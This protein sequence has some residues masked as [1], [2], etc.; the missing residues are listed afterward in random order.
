MSDIQ[1]L[2]V[3]HCPLKG[4]NLVEASAGTGKTWNLCGLYLRLILEAGLTVQQILVVTFT[5]AATAEL[6][7][8]IRQR[9]L[10]TLAYLACRT[11]GEDP[12]SEPTPSAPSDPSDHADPFVRGLLDALLQGAGAGTADGAT[13]P[14]LPDYLHRLQQRL[15]LALASFDEAAI[16]TIHGFC[17]RALTDT[18][19]STGMPFTL[20]LCPD[21]R[22]L[23]R[24][25]V[26]AAWRK[27]LIQGTISPLLA[28]HLI[29]EKES[30]ETWETLLAQYQEKPLAR[31]RWP[32]ALATGDPLALPGK[33]PDTLPPGLSAS[34]AA[35]RAL[36]RAEREDI[37]GSLSSA[38]PGQLNANSY[39]LESV[40]AG[41]EWWDHYFAQ[42]LPLDFPGRE[43]DRHPGAK[44]LLFSQARIALRTKKGKESPRHPFFDLVQTLLEE[45]YGFTDQLQDAHLGLRKAMLEESSAGLRQLKQEQRQVAFDDLLYQVYRALA[46]ANDGT[47]PDLASALRSRYPAA[48]IDEFQDTDPLQYAIFS[49]IYPPQAS[50][51]GG[52]TGD[53]SLFLI[54]DPK[55]A[56]Y[57]FRNADLHTYLAARHATPRHYTLRHNQRSL[58]PLIQGCNALF[59]HNPRAFLLPGL[60]FTPA[61]A[62]EK[63]RP[64][65]E[66]LSRTPAADPGGGFVLWTLPRADADGGNGAGPDAATTEPR[67]LSREA[68][69]NRV[70]EA[71]AGEIARLLGAARAGRLRCDGQAVS[72][73]QIAVLVR[74]HA[75]GSLIKAALARRGIGSVELA[76]ASVFA[77][78][79]AQEL[80]W[81]LAAIHEPSRVARVRGALATGLMGW[82]A[83][84]I[85]ALEADERALQGVLDRFLS[86]REQWLRRGFVR[87]FRA[88]LEQAGIPGRLLAQAD[89]ERRLTNLLHLGELI[90]AAH[91]DPGTPPETL[92]NWL[93]E[94]RER[95]LAGR[96]GSTDTTQLRLESDRNLVQIV[97]IHKS[98]GLEYEFVFCPFLWD[99]QPPQ[100]SEAGALAYHDAD[101]T[102]VLD[103]RILGDAER[104]AI[105]ERQKED[106]DAEFL[107]LVYVALTRAVLR[108]YLVVGIYEGG[109]TRTSTGQSGRGLLNW[110]AAGAGLDPS[111]WASHK[112]PA[113]TVEAAWSA[114]AAAHP[115][116]FS[117][118][119]L[120]RLPGGSGEAA[121]QQDF[122]DLPPGD[123]DGAPLTLAALTPPRLS[124]GFRTGSF[125]H[126]VAGLHH[127]PP[128]PLDTREEQARDHDA[129]AV[130]PEEER[131]PVNEPPAPAPSPQ[132]PARSG[133]PRPVD[134]RQGTLDLGADPSPAAEPGLPLADD[135]LLFPR[136][137][138]AG[139]CLHAMLE[140]GEFTDPGTWDAAIAR[141]LTEFPQPLPAG[142][143]REAQTTQWQAMA[144]RL[145]TSV[146][147]TPLPALGP[148]GE[149][150]SFQLGHLEPA[151]RRA[152]MEFHLA[153]PGLSQA[154]LQT[155]LR[156]AGYPL[157]DL[158]PDGVPMRYLKGFMD[159]V[160]C[161]DGRYYVLDWKSNHLGDREG[162]YQAA[163]M[164]RAMVEHAYSLQALLYLVA[165]HRLLRFRLPDYDYDRH[166][167]GALYL[168]LRGV[169]PE[170][171]GAGIHAHR[172]SHATVAALDALLRGA[173]N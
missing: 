129:Q 164:Q 57:S 30:P 145:L 18:P 37:V 69:R 154:R 107:R 146:M 93:A 83:P 172:P 20:E 66:D 22:E 155:W 12:G 72:P 117:L 133:R 77:T 27:H 106:E 50:A 6:R 26:L 47:A 68:A 46:E 139:D 5:N 56:I 114:L 149:I 7:E 74:S 2:D 112:L 48:L 34:F 157:P 28:A 138:A 58:E 91:P 63:P 162:D 115:E 124:P 99:A 36:W 64:V 87:M 33:L 31:L 90:Q 168:F 44:A 161:H 85:L 89:G 3:F 148:Q 82:S 141:A 103:F 147:T 59:S 96:E 97:T 79:D 142:V 23:R 32:D 73:G 40:T 84:E 166:V 153:S 165:L 173:E 140:Y 170:W 118:E 53:Y 122:L 163:G 51:D 65:L 78:T 150:G 126:L 134:P 61:L 128:P 135:I 60:T 111:E 29:R 125:S 104:K 144:K 75:Q 131:P 35:A 94:R 92:L 38:I 102:P 62:G 1:D 11:E 159:L 110:L 136:G 14:S 123:G 10:D 116:A 158:G 43:D 41:A 167:G 113:E 169:R 13:R 108:C 19:F 171:P 76:Q 160:F 71:T 120:P 86:A 4:A 130:P 49:H 137:P 101:G 54:G 80:E 8:R 81:L 95:A 9:L 39:R 42:G 119:E 100:R 21:D 15:R 105:A 17:Q 152:E 151:A 16:H 70:V 45:I 109:P 127:R 88:W 156:N 25:A 121:A 67:W 132:A 24:E 98:K 55:Q 52:Q 143:E